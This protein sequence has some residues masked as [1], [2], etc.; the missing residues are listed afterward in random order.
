[1]DSLAIGRELHRI[2]L[3]DLA[4]ASVQVLK[5]LVPTV[6][7]DL[8]GG[9]AGLAVAGTL[10]VVKCASSAST[11]FNTSITRI[12]P[13]CAA[14][15]ASEARLNRVASWEPAPSTSAR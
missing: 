15:S 10:H 4:V 3:D 7:A 12:Y 2:V 13:D 6:M 1:M 5:A 9:V 14:I 8:A 11:E